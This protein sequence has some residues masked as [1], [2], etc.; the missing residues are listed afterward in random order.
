M[1][2]CPSGV[3]EPICLSETSPE[4]VADAFLAY[5]DLHG[6]DMYHLINPPSM[7]HSDLTAF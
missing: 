1:I 3:K 6:G 7:I 2:N 4:T 5:L